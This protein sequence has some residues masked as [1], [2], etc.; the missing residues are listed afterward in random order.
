MKRSVDF[1]ISATH[2]SLVGHFPGNPIVPAVLLL[3][4]VRCQLSELISD[5]RIGEI[6]Q[7]KFYSPLLPEQQALL[8][9][10]VND[11]RVQFS[12]SR[13]DQLITRGE[14]DLTNES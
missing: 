4:Q 1:S 12:V 11:N 13:A 6:R 14:I 5:R 2:P 10:E 3:E 9:L 8:D 7:V